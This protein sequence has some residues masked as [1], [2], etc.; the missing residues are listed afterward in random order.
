VSREIAES[1]GLERPAGAL[2][3]DLVE[4]GPA[5]QAGLRRGDVVIEVDGQGVDDPESLGYRLG[6][7]TIGAN[8]ALAVQRN[9]RKVTLPLKLIAAP[10]SPPRE[11]LTLGGRSPF[12]GVTVVNLSPAVNEEFSIEAF[13][14]GVVITEVAPGTPA[15]NVGLQMGDVILAVNDAKIA[16]TGDLQKVAEPRRSWWKLTLGRGGQIITTALGG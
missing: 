3:A 15:A 1:L 2:V 6:T 8:A 5:A 14:E 12:S 11:P 16:R 4:A 9:G 10:E 7:K 13:R